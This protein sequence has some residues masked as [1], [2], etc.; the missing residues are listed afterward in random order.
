MSCSLRQKVRYRPYSYHD[1]L[2][3]MRVLNLQA[4]PSGLK[5]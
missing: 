3:I 1:S 4:Q 2:R 5:Y